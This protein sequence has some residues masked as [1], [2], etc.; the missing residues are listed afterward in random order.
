MMNE[1]VCVVVD[2]FSTGRYLAKEFLSKGYRSLHVQSTPKITSDLLRAFEPSDFI[3]N[4]QHGG[5]L[6]ATLSEIR[7]YDVACVMAG[8][9]SGVELADSLSESLN[10]LTNGSRLSRARRDKFE[11]K[12]V[13]RAK[14]V[15]TAEYMKAGRASDIVD[16]AREKRI[17]KVVLKPV[18]SAGTDNVHI[19]QSELEIDATFRQIIGREN[20][21]GLV[22]EEV[23][24]EEFL[25]GVE[26]VVNTVS[27]DKVHYI[28]EIWRCKKRQVMGAS[29]HASIYDMAAM[30][31]PRRGRPVG[32]SRVHAQSFGRS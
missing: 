32:T 26:H 4:I 29:A 23:L 28:A 16:W 25:E 6:N 17:P 19:C 5:D 30:L 20:R 10:L 11:M 12:E 1:Q 8:T 22:N 27:K 2:A 15:R 24:V 21:L 9:E 31:P 14:G 18:N 7:R 13:L 3:E